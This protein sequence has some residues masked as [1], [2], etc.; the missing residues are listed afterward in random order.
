MH[1]DVGAHRRAA[2]V[3]QWFTSQFKALDAERGRRRSVDDTRQLRGAAGAGFGDVIELRPVDRLVQ[4]SGA[5]GVQPAPALVNQNAGIQVGRIEHLEEALGAAFLADQRAVA[6]REAGS[7][8][9]QMRT[10]TGR[11]FLVVGDDHDFRS[12]Q[13]SV[14]DFGVYTAIQIVFQYHDGV[15]LTGNHCLQGGI[16]RIATKHRQTHAVGF[17][18][19]QAD[20]ALLVTQLQGLGNVCRRLDQRCRT[21]RAAGNDQRTFGREQ[22][23][24]NT[25]RQ[26]QRLAVQTFY[27]RCAG[28][29]GMSHGKTDTRQIIGRCMYAFFCNIVETGFGEAGDEQ[30]IELVLTD[31]L[32]GRVEPRLDFHRRSHVFSL[33]FDGLAQAQ[34]HTCRRLGQV[35]AEDEDGIVIFDVAQ[36][37]D[38]QRAVVQ[39]L[40]D[41]PDTLQLTGFDTAVE[42]LGSDQF[43]Q[44][45]VAFEAGARRADTDDVAA[46]QQIRCLVQ[47]FVKA[48]F[49]LAFSEQWLTWTVCAVDVAVAETAS[50]AEKVLVDRAVVAVFDTAQFTVTLTWA[51]VAAAGATVADAWRELHVPLAVVA[52]GVGLVGEH[53]GRTDLGE[54]AGE[55]AFQRAVFNATEV[56]IVVSAVNAQVS[57]ACVVF[58][59]AYAPITGDAAVHLMR[60]ER[61]QLL[62][63]VSTLGEAI[64]A[65]VVAGHHCHVLQVAVTAFFAD[66]AVMRVVGHQ[67]FDD[68]GPEGLGLFIFD[69]DPGVV[70]G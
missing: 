35:L 22:G 40:E 38:R 68:T 37:R 13:R 24:G 61:P 70:G 44:C 67:P 50:V 29:Q 52:L 59:E 3:A 16:D 4:Q 33:A 28:V 53:T 56:N 51:D 46:A 66:W 27:G 10:I 25:L 47:C 36:G 48:Q 14:D 18:H 49:D 12:A 19:D 2:T 32:H 69:G 20:G 31:V 39:D 57:A 58:I 30:R 9:D 60:D 43:T 64:T 55:L 26:F 45:V 23:I 5:Q 17:R 6:F 65:L 42:M 8:Q 41:Q 11:G 21:Q 15:G 63:L 54:V 34:G 7:W 62:I 1:A